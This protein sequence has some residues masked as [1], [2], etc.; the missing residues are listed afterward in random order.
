MC[1]YS[2][3]FFFYRTT[4]RGNYHRWF[5]T[6]SFTVIGIV[7]SCDDMQS[8]I[9]SSQ[10]EPR[11]SLR[12][13]T[14]L[15]S[16]SRNPWPGWRRPDHIWRTPS[17]QDIRGSL[18]NHSEHEQSRGLA[19]QQSQEADIGENA[20]ETFADDALYFFSSLNVSCSLSPSEQ[21]VGQMEEL[22]VFD[23]RV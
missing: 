8:E 10:T 1:V 20:R 12:Y 9:C 6:K 21:I 19:L 22:C 11:L 13:N 14:F 5:W 4:L 7:S 15:W 17:G 18:G 16:Y 2:F 3:P 23:Q